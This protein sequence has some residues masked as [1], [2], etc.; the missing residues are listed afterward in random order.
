MTD[1]K[2]SKSV[3]E[4]TPEL[5]SLGVAWFVSDEKHTSSQTT[6][7]NKL[8]ATNIDLANISSYRGE[9]GRMALA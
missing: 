9:F 1:T 7:F 4:F 6:L 2:V 5:V 3:V 8:D